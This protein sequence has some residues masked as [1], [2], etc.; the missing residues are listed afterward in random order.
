M[1]VLVCGGAGYIGSH[2]VAQLLARGEA[3]VVADNL[4]KGHKQALLGGAFME[5]DIRDSAFLERVFEAHD[6]DAAIDFAALIEVG[7]SMQSPLKYYD[8]NVLSAIRLLEAM[9]KRGVKHLV[10]SSTA[11]VYGR[12]ET[13][14]ITEDFLKQPDNAYGAGKLAVE[15]LLRWCERAYGVTSASLRYF[16]AC[17]AME[18]GEI[19]EDHTPETHLIPNILRAMMGLQPELYLFGSDYPTKDGTCVRDYIHVDDL[20]DAHL[21]ALDRLRGGGGSDVFNLGN[22]VGFT[23]WE[24]IKAAE[25]VTGRKAPVVMAARR[26]GDSVELVASSEKARR[27]LGWAP[28][29]TD[30]EDIIAT[31]WNWHSKHPAGFAV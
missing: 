11:A 6:I 31:A 10:F 24:V 27:V 12:V 22:G 17:G 1:A 18:S 14:P 13:S 9:V 15:G 23:V 19:G 4:S 30:L 21:R 16:N 29:Y 26:E 3:V 20:V 25:R 7:E 28:K 5:G 8:N 2:C